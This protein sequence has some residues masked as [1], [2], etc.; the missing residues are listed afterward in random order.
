MKI[1]N[2]LILG[3][4]LTLVA[5]APS[6]P[7][8]NEP[9]VDIYAALN[10]DQIEYASDEAEVEEEADSASPQFVEEQITQAR[11]LFFRKK[12]TEASDLLERMVRLDSQNANAYYWLAR[13]RMEQGDFNQAHEL[14]KKGL[15]VVSD[16]RL[17][18]ELE[19]VKGITQMGAE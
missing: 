17:K 11:T 16:K 1:Q 5:C 15:T 18:A 9:E 13:V 6:K 12:Y 14:S 10:D 8:N 3:C 19:R 7:K 2:I 4:V